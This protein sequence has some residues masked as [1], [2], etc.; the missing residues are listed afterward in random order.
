MSN[1]SLSAIILSVL[2]LIGL[3]AACS[4][5]QNTSDSALAPGT[6]EQPGVSALRRSAAFV[7]NAG[8]SDPAVLFSTLGSASTLFFA[9][10]EVVFPLPSPDRRAGLLSRLLGSG[11]VEPATPEEPTNLYLRFEGVS[12]DTQVLGEEQLPGIVNY[13]IGDDPANWHA[14]IPTYA[15][16]VYE[17]LYP[18]IDLFY[19]GSQS[20]LKGTYVVAPGADPGDIRW[21]Y[22]G[23]SNVELSKGELLISTT[24][25]G[26]A[27]SLVERQP[28]AWQT[29][30]GKR[31]HVGIRYVI[32]RDGSIGFAL[33][34]YD[35]AQPLM[36]DP[37]LDYSTYVGG[38]K[39]E[40][41]FGVS[42]DASNNVYIAGSTESKSPGNP[43]IFVVKLDPSQAGANQ[44][45]YET[46]I[47]GSGEEVPGGIGVDSNGNVYVAGYSDSTDFPVKNEYQTDQGGRDAV[48]VQLNAAGAVN[49]ASYLGGSSEDEAHQVAVG[50][51]G[52]MHVVG[53]TGSD[54]FPTKNAFQGAHASGGDTFVAVVDPSKS[55]NASLVYSTYYGGSGWDQGWAIDVLDGIIYF[56]GCT[57]SN[58][59]PLKNAIQQTY[60]GT[61]G[62]LGDAYV[63]K[64][65][66]S[67]LGANQLLFAT[68]LGG[69]GDDNIGGI[70]VDASGDVYVAGVTGV[71]KGTGLADFPTTAISPPYGGGD[72]DG[73]LVKLRTNSASL[74]FSR[75]VGGGGNDGG[76]DIVLDTSG[77]TYVTGGTGSDDFPT[78]NPIQDSFRGGTG[79][80]YPKYL[81]GL[82]L[83][84]GDA[85]VAR[86]DATST[87]TFGT[88]LGGSGDEAGLGIALD[89]AGS[90]YVTGGTESIDFDTVNPFQ[91]ANA[92]QFD[93]FV[94]RISKQFTLTVKKTGSGDG[95]VASAPGG[96]SCGAD[97]T[98]S[99]V[100]DTVVTLT[101]TPDANSAF[102][103][104]SGDCSGADP[105]TT[106]TMDADR[107]CTATFTSYTLTVNKDGGGA[108]TVTSAPVGISCGADCTEN[109]LPDT[110]VTLTAH[111]GVKS[112]FVGWDGDC[113]GT[114][115]TATVTMD[116]NKVCIAT[117][118]WPVGGVVVPVNKL[119]LLAPWMGLAAL[120]SLAA[121]TVALVRR[122]GA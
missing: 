90:I 68:Y 40:G 50:D 15:S 51:N 54:D 30:D 78:V 67:L 42:V 60:G 26:E 13:F 33:G 32:H 101:A 86:F 27:G 105:T 2:L 10:H 38:V 52:L 57:N 89:V 113:S 116:A 92:G 49:Y 93:D 41:S 106:V 119:K 21:R 100:I 110:V 102:T 1:R 74:I 64:L 55:G 37:T 79:A 121:L 99:Y 84:P 104:W 109:Y 39:D 70:A 76:R 83:G 82:N 45:V 9:R 103:G 8:Q 12:P 24:E 95:T 91:D 72:W 14:N 88:Y 3:L 6:D 36:I 118:G 53:D 25:T 97:C 59:L 20:V 58:D 81:Y 7:P 117:F 107:T 120:V 44:L 61:G 46:Y 112:Y 122:R 28:L 18:G 71:N 34:K 4:P 87:M 47:G 85:F 111:P 65:D 31:R 115:P 43:D 69:G 63:A 23:A 98:E 48:V 19:N 17:Q 66:P 80:S 5:L 77:N 29:V 75:F 22:D 108:G 94:A 16:I 62:L 56:A 114:D 96:I 73:F 35:V 11:E